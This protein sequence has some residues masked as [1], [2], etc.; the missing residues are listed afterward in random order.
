MI[1]YIILVLFILSI[2][3]MFWFENKPIRWWLR[4]PIINLFSFILV[5]VFTV[6]E[7]IYLTFHPKERTRWIKSS[8]KQL[9]FE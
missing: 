1:T 2:A 7:E 5:L 3:L 6:I 9:F 4:L 8:F